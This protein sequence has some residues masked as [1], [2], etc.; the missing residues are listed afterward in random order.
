M[1]P[2]TV[3]GGGVWGPS[4]AAEALEEFRVVFPPQPARG[5]C[6]IAVLAPQILERRLCGVTNRQTTLV[7]WLDLAWHLV[8][9]RRP[10]Y[11]TGP[12]TMRL[13]CWRVSSAC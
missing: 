5:C 6:F 8:G 2:R 1:R 12:A 3:A 9:P 4:M 7:A 10:G 13:P 11:D